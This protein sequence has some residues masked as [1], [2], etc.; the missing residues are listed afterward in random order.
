[1]VIAISS[2]G[3]NNGV[4]ENKIFLIDLNLLLTDYELATKE[5]WSKYFN[6]LKNIIANNISIEDKLVIFAHNL[7]N[8]DGYFLYRGL[9]SCYHP[10]KVTSI[11][12]DSNTFIS[13]SCNA[14]GELIEFKDSLRIFPMS[15]NN[16]CEMFAVEGKL[17]SYN[18]MFTKL[19]FFNKPKL[20]QEFI[21]Y[22]LQDA[23]SLFEAL[24]NAKNLYFTKFGV[25]IES[26]YSTAT[27]SLK[28]YR[29]KF[30]ELPI[31]IC[32]LLL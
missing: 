7:G 22:S 18:S 32:S 4:L 1:V 20:L 16:L 14:L 2:C 30:Q 9:M 19:E 28:I 29:T 27:L 31:F 21:N 11:I 8:F 6:Y 26:V 24:L 23:K 25:D 10:D 17:T 12:D 3:F 5:L 13:I 15:L